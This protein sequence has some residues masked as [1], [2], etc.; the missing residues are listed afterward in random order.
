MKHLRKNQCHDESDVWCDD[1]YSAGPDDVAD[2]MQADCDACLIAA[3]EFGIL[4]MRRRLFLKDGRI[5]DRHRAI[6]KL[7]D[8]MAHP[9]FFVHPK[10]EG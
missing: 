9:I 6:E 4:A 8:Q 3:F 1:A 5:L 2:P 7:L 10:K